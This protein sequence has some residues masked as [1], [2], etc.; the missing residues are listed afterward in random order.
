VSGR[1]IVVDDRFDRV[2]E[3]VERILDRVAER[4]GT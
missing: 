1:K 3:R 2:E 4:P